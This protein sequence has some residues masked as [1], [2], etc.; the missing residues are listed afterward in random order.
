MTAAILV[1]IA[2]CAVFWLI[3]FRLKLLRLTPGWAIVFT[4]F[5][6]HLFL[7][8]LIGLRFMTPS[9][10]NATVVQHTIQLIPRLP[11]PTLVTDVLV[12]EN[13]LVK[14]GQPLFQL[15]RRPY[16]YKVEQVQAQ[17]AA[18][19]QNVDVLRVDV[20]VSLQKPSDQRRSSNIWSTRRPYSTSSR[21][22]AQR[23]KRSLSNG[24]PASA[25][26]KPPER[27]RSPS[28]NALAS[29]TN[30]RST[31]STHRSRIWR[32]NSS[33]RSTT[34]TIRR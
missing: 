7:V 3:F 20:D 8:F 22:Q 30:P 27:R 17:L 29:S 11:E 13:A 5:V 19:K 25:R 15:D 18:A 14:K 1:I 12:E 16:A 24:R 32:R 6:L 31:A 34:W 9:S 4:F 2:A 33:R 28:S 23:V 26:R 10:A 21:R